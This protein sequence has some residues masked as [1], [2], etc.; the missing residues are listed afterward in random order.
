MRLT[1]VIGAMKI[2]GEKHL[3]NASFVYARL[4]GGA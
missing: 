4:G 3:A 2:E 1:V